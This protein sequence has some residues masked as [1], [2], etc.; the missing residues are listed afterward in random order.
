MHLH[1]IFPESIQQ[2]LLKLFVLRQVGLI[3]EANLIVLLLPLLLLHFYILVG[4]K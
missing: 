2:V 4:L 1:A 3:I